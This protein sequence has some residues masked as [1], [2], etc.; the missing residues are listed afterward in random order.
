MFRG[1]GMQLSRVFGIRINQV[2]VIILFGMILC[3][4]I[5][6]V[7]EGACN[8]VVFCDATC[9]C[10]LVFVSGC[11]TAAVGQTCSCPRDRRQRF[12]NQGTM[13]S[14][15]LGGGASWGP[16]KWFEHHGTVGSRVLGGGA[17]IVSPLCRVT[18]V[19]RTVNERF[20]RPSTKLKLS[21]LDRI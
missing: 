5:I 4:H 1:L 20:K 7:G 10:V 13:V 2:K 17:L 21:Y 6:F 16:L 15:G 19:S 11:K 14:R 12:E 3:H 18:P 9:S 8:W